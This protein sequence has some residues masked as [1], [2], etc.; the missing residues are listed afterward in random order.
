ML[1]ME[2]IRSLPIEEKVAYMIVVRSVVGDRIDEMLERGQIAALGG[3]ALKDRKDL[4]AAVEELNGWRRK[5]RLPLMFFADGEAGLAATFSFAT[6]LPRVM[7]ATAA[8]EAAEEMARLH[9]R[10]V[11]RECKA[12]GIHILGSPCVDVNIDPDNPIICNRAFSDDADTVVRLARAYTA[13]LQEEGIIGTAKHFP[14]H[15]ATN[16]DSHMAMPQVDRTLEELFDIELRPYREILNDLWGVMTAHIHYPALAAEGEE[17]VPATMSRTMLYDLL[18]GKLGYENLIVSDSLTM[19]G[20]KD[21]YGL[22]AAVGAINAGH[23][24]IL[25]DYASDPTL[26]YDL[27][28]EAVKNGTI[29]EE[30]VNDSAARI[31]KFREKLGVTNDLLDLDEVRSVIGCAEHVRDAERIARSS[32]TRINC[33]SLPFDAKSAKKTLV[34]ATVGPEEL[35]ETEDMGFTG[36]ASSF[37]TGNEVNKFVSADLHRISEIPTKEDVDAVLEKAQGYDT[38]IAATFVR[39]VSYKENSGKVDPEILRMLEVLEQS[40][41]QFVSLV[42]GN[43]YV[44]SLMP[45]FQNCLLA[46]SDDRFSVK[47]MVEA[48]FGAFDPT[49]VLPVHVSE[50]YPRGYSCK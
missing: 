25:Q 15:G 46:Y 19:K 39:N 18:R 6:R 7:A 21:K 44:L 10:I 28:L 32:V 12:M 37:A 3:T 24:M 27:V 8:G 2:E 23:D 48:V 36:V 5:A 20:V 45:K 26:T 43:P 9:A 30:Q 31:L 4:A 17:G 35:A 41:K 34:I 50:T 47:A 42:F 49:G 22:E 38:V 33:T 14:G 40:D 11:A 29:S 13:A 16:V 1:S